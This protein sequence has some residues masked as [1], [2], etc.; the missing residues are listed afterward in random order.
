MSNRTKTNNNDVS[1]SFAS[2]FPDFEPQAPIDNIETNSNIS[3]KG[4]TIDEKLNTIRTETYS[5]N[6]SI[7]LEEYCV[8]ICEWL[9]I[10]KQAY[11]ILDFYE[12]DANKPFL[13]PLTET[14]KDTNILKLLEYR[15]SRDASKGILRGTI[16]NDLM[17]NLY[18]WADKKQVELQGDTMKFEF[19]E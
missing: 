16:T 14:V 10:N 17:K 2:L 12:D 18:G 9:R 13:Y 11:S 4:D 7:S 3:I 6:E 15:I 19:G 1:P 5:S 8:V